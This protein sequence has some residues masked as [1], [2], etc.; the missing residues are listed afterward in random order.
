MECNCSEN[1]LDRNTG[2]ILLLKERTTDV[3]DV[4]FKAYCI[5]CGKSQEIYY[6]DFIFVRAKRIDI[7]NVKFS[8]KVFV[9][10]YNY[11][12]E[13]LGSKQVQNH[14]VY[15]IMTAI[16][17][18]YEK[19]YNMYWEKYLFEDVRKA[20]VTVLSSNKYY[21]GKKTFL[22]RMNIELKKV[23]KE[24]FSL[25]E[26]QKNVKF[27]EFDEVTQKKYGPYDI[28]EIKSDI[29]KLQNLILQELV[30]I[31]HQNYKGGDLN[32]IKSNDKLSLKS[33]QEFVNAVHRNNI[34]LRGYSIV[35]KDLF[36][37]KF[38]TSD[39][40]NSGNYKEILLKLEKASK[41]VLKYLDN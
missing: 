24:L 16:V 22:E 34:F 23:S 27:E 32:K 33:I 18:A 36:N 28:I 12:M 39:D 3:Y 21:N 6:K 19:N 40:I 10:E 35:F 13:L 17:T 25:E 5:K 41:F 2:N 8:P 20:I 15:N 38:V 14:I 31:L 30:K 7:E 26:F 9:R 4:F 37:L 11:V 29:L 1:S